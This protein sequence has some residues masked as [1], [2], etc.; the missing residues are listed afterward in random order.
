M[1]CP[2]PSTCINY[3]ANV[4]PLEIKTIRSRSLGNTYLRES[5]LK[6]GGGSGAGTKNYTDGGWAEV[7]D[8][9][10][11]IYFHPLPNIFQ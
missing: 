8:G 9:L 1:S 5:C 3:G 4:F 10:E 7:G 6:S 2:L 11:I